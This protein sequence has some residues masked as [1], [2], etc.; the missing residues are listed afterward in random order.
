MKCPHCGNDRVTEKDN[1]CGFCGKKLKKVCNCWVKKGSY[2]CEEDSCPGYE[3][4]VKEAR[5]AL[6][7]RRKMAIKL[8]PSSMMG[9]REEEKRFEVIDATNE[10]I[11][12]I[13]KIDLTVEQ[14]RRVI[15][16]LELAVSKSTDESG[17]KIDTF[18]YCDPFGR[19]KKRP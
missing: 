12:K 14:I 6:E 9:I 7:R 18:E 5:N 4:I 8:D 16:F 3:L 17:I 10:F 19:P 15:K 2:D 1:F 11:E 13:N